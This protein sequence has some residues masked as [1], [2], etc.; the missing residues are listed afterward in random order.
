MDD[1]AAAVLDL[2]TA[3]APSPAWARRS[4]S[5]GAA[6]V[7]DLVGTDLREAAAMH[8]RL[9]ERF[10]DHVWEVP[11]ALLT[12]GARRRRVVA[13][14][15]LRHQL[16]W[17]SRSGALPGRVACLA[18]EIVSAR[19]ARAR[20]AALRPLLAHHL[21]VLDR[22]VMTDI[23][24]AT[25]ALSAVRR[26]Q[27]SLAGELDE[28]RLERLLE[29]DAFRTDELLQPARSIRTTVAAWSRDVE[30][31]GGRGARTLDAITLGCWV[32]EIEVHLE[33]IAQGLTELE[34]LGHLQP[35]LQETVDALVLREQAAVA[36]AAP[37]DATGA[38]PDGK[39]SW[40]AS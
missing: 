18:E 40:S 14:L 1:V 30:A 34:R 17:A 32:G 23:D 31:A 21:G 4:A 36:T 5:E 2:S 37:A 12:T 25:E 28:E 7:L 13:H 26:L 10:T 16:R 38:S 3:P 20:V 29:A 6:V 8:A 35:T 24:A 27:R 19:A 33:P 39:R 11:T 22:G 9:Y 15:R